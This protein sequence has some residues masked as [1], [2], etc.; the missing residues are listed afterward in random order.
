[1]K[2]TVISKLARL[3][4]LTAIAA[5]AI[6]A[7]AQAG[8]FRAQ[9]EVYVS[10]SYI[11]ANVYNSS[12]SSPARCRV[13]VRGLRQDGMWARNVVNMTLMP[14]GM[15]YAYL[16]SNYVPFIDGRA[17]AWCYTRGY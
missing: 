7:D 12:Y 13:E 17:S 10:P 15:Q 11:Q 14:G 2:K 8:R 5:A 9:A 6:G 3:F 4:T 1:M 16:Y